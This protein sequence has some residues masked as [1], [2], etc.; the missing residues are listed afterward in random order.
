MR[1]VCVRASVTIFFSELGCLGIKIFFQYVTQYY[2]FLARVA[3]ALDLLF[4]SS[5][6]SCHTF[7]QKIQIFQ[8]FQS[9]SSQL[10]LKLFLSL[11]P[12]FVRLSIFPHMFFKKRKKD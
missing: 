4:F 6:F 9:P 10:F 1:P 2:I 5:F 12:Q 7:P 3:K 8:F 11:F